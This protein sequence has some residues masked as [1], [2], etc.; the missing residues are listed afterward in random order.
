MPLRKPLKNSGK[1]EKSS[2]PF[3]Q[4][5]YIR[6]AGSTVTKRHIRILKASPSMIELSDIEISKKTTSSINEIDFSTLR[7][8]DVFSDHMFEMTYA[9]G[10]WS[11]PKI[12]PYGPITIHPSASILHYG[13][14]VFEGMKGFTYSDGRVNIFRPG[15][16]YQRFIRSQARMNIPVVPEE[17]FMSAM[18]RLVDMDRNWVPKDKYKSLYIRPFVVATDEYLGLKTSDSYKFY[19]ITGPVGNYY[20]EGINPVSLTT[21]PEYVRAVKGGSGEAKVPGNYAN[22]IYPAWLAKQRGYTQVLWLDALEHKYVEEVGSMNI[23]FMIDDTLI[24]APLAGTILPGV[25]RECVMYLAKQWGM[26]VEERPISIDELIDAGKTG[27]LTEVFGSGTAAVISPVGH[28]H[29]DGQE[30]ELDREKM[31]PVARKM[32]DTITGIH[33]GEI[34]DPAGWCHLI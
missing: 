9:N 24:T 19:I 7:F 11:S 12:Y 22:S 15:R 29:H 4:F 3:F 21:M 5:T 34:D 20:A 16:H 14:G 31:G 33:H 18:E 10:Y 26:N 28:I 30:I 25:T 1:P 27:R 13:Q 32:Y 23:F 8:G 2:L 6:L 17:F